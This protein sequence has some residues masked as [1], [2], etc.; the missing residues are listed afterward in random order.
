VEEGRPRKVVWLKGEYT[1]LVEM[2]I[3]REEWQG[4]GDDA[5]R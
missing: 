5:E 2:S 3:L 4:A 1:D